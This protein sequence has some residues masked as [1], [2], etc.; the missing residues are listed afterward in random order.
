MACVYGEDELAEEEAQFANLAI[1]PYLK[2]LFTKENDYSIIGP[3]KSSKAAKAA[4]AKVDKSLIAPKPDIL[5]TKGNVMELMLDESI[6][7]KSGHY[8]VTGI[9]IHVFLVVRTRWI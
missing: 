8:V 2:M 5:I 7:S 1:M 3:T 4:Y 6:E 9:H